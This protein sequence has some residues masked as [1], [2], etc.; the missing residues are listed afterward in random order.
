MWDGRRRAPSIDACLVGG[1]CPPS[2]IN[3]GRLVVIGSAVLVPPALLLIEDYRGAV[4]DAAAI[5]MTSA[6]LFA[7]VLVR[8]AGLARDAA[9]EKSEA[10]FRALV[11]NA[12]GRHPGDRRRRLGCAYRTPSTERMLGRSPPSSRDAGWGEFLEEVDEQSLQVMLAN[13]S[14]TAVVDWRIRRGDGDWRDL[15]VV[16]A[17]MRGTA[18]VDGL[19]LTMRDITDRKR[20]DLELRQQALHDSLTGLANRTLFM[21]R[22][23]QALK[24]SQRR[25]D[26]IGVLLLDLDDFKLVNDTFG[27]A[28]ADHL[29]IAVADRLT[30]AISSGVTLARLGGDEF[31]LLFDNSTF[32][33]GSDLAAWCKRACASHS[34]CEVRKSRAREHGHGSRVTHSHSPDD[35]LREADMAMYVAKRNG[36]EPIRALP[37]RDARGGDSSPRDCRRPARRHRSRRARRLLPTDRRR[38]QRTHARRRDT[39]ALA[40]PERGWLEPSEFIPVAEATSLVVPLGRWVLLDAC[41]QGPRMEKNAASPPTRSTSAINLSAHHLQDPDVVHDVTAALELSGLSA[42]ALV[43]EVTESALIEDLTKA[44]STLATLKCLGL[45]IAVDDFGTGYSSLSYLSNFPIDVI[46]LDKSFIDGSR[47]PRRRDYGSRCPRSRAHPWSHGDRR[48]RRRRRAG[49]NAGAPRVAISRRGSSSPAD[50]GGRDGCTTRA[51]VTDLREASV[52]HA[53]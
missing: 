43:L 23:D 44:G 19:V 10:R 34:S 5:A 53:S 12:S 52:T 26:S 9:D 40:E 39:R 4:H 32:D 41:P 51:P 45:R 38:Q 49:T 3:A 50:A 28:A 21:D 11:D 18:H 6:A 36:K 46:K 24:R 15:E 31:A 14:A 47:R 2:R 48:R 22:V 20:L 7:L 17:D 29:L 16:S 42:A 27:H 30:I 8:I 1:N 25:D 13:E 35:V 33:T 37:P